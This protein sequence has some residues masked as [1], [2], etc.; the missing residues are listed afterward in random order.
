MIEQKQ[1]TSF[2]AMQQETKGKKPN[3]DK[4]TVST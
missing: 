4:W 1:K 2:Q 3:S